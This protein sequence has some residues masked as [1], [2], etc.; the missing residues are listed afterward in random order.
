MGGTI[1][2]GT[3]ATAVSITMTVLSCFIC[4]EN[5]TD[6]ERIMKSKVFTVTYDT[7]EEMVLAQS[8]MKLHIT[9]VHPDYFGAVFLDERRSEETAWHETGKA[10]QPVYPVVY[11][12]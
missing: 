7:E 5:R 11:F 8:R 1:V 10:G 3:V 12:V 9:E 2:T 6:E 4:T